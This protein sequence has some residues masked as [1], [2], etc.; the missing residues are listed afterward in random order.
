M[1][2]WLQPWKSG[3]RSGIIPI[4]AV[5]K[6]SY[7]GLKVLMLWAERQ[8]K[9][10]PLAEWLTY[11]QCQEAGGQVRKGEKSTPGI[12][13]N[14]QVI[15]KGTDEER[16]VPFMRTF[17]LFNVSQCD[18]LTIENNGIDNKELPEHDRNEH[19]PR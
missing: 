4:N 11:K 19:S 7:S 10:H 9:Q 13:V 15:E 6:K 17:N 2:V 1:P 18:G 3:K 8:E 12:Y 14:K 16:L 5:T